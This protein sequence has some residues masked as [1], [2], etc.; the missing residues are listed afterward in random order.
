MQVK[1]AY[2]TLKQAIFRN[3]FFPADAAYPPGREDP[4]K[5]IQRVLE[6]K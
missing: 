3:Y 5:A 4:F 6:K 1:A 2:C